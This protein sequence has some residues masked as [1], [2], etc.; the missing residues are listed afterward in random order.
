MAAK[1]SG[2]GSGKSG[3]QKDRDAPSPEAIINKFQR[4]RSEQRE[5]ASKMNELVSDRREHR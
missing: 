2:T 3:K 1:G 5:I 4:M